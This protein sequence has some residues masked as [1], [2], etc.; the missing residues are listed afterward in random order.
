MAVAD[1]LIGPDHIGQGPGYL[2]DLSASPEGWKQR[3]TVYRNAFPDVQFSIEEQIAAGDMV[4]T[5]FLSRGTHSGELAGS[6]PTGNAIS[7]DGIL[8]ARVVNGKIVESWGILDQFGFRQQL[9]LIP[10]A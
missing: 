8:E 4:M 2:P 3:V 10:A 1:E 7:T 5:R 9:G 6:P